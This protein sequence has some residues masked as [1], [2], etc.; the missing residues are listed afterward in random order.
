MND[1]IS[2]IP[3]CYRIYS[4]VFFVFQLLFVFLIF[5][6]IF[7]FWEILR[8]RLLIPHKSFFIESSIAV[9]VIPFIIFPLFF[10]LA[11]AG[12]FRQSLIIIQLSLLF[13]SF[14]KG[15]ALKII[16]KIRNKI[17]LLS[18]GEYVVLAFLSFFAYW[19]WIMPFPERFNGHFC[20]II[21][22]IQSMWKSGYFIAITKEWLNYDNQAYIWPPNAS[23]FLSFFSMPYLKFIDIRP[24]FLVP[25][26][27]LFLAWGII[28]ENTEMLFHDHKIGNLAFLLVVFSYNHLFN[29]VIYYDIFSPLIIALFM[30]FFILVYKR[31]RADSINF[32]ILAVSFTYMARR[33]LFLLF[34]AIISIAYLWNIIKTRNVSY[35]LKINKKLLILF[36]IPAVFWATFTFV[37]YKSPFFPHGGHFVEKIFP[38]SVQKPL[39]PYTFAESIQP[40]KNNSEQASF[41]KQQIIK[42]KSIKNHRIP[43][44]NI[45]FYVENFFPVHLSRGFFTFIK[46]VFCGLSVSL[47][48]SI[49]FL[50]FLFA[51]FFIKGQKDNRE[52]AWLFLIGYTIV[53]YI[54]FLSYIRYAQ[55]LAYI[56]SPFSSYFYFKALRKQ[57]FLKGLMLILFCFGMIFWAYNEWGHMSK[58][59]SLENIR[60]LNPSYKNAVS[61]LAKKSNRSEIGIETE[62]KEILKARAKDS[63]ILYM[64]IEPGLLIPTILNLENFADSLFLE[65]I[66]AEKL[67]EAKSFKELKNGINFYGITHIYKPGRSHVDFENTLLLRMLKQIKEYE[68]LVPVEELSKLD[69]DK[70]NKTIY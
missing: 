57:V 66:S 55:Y 28:K 41:L 38:A 7:H 12:W 13:L 60:F 56:I 39:E 8:T 24:L 29:A 65:S 16:S 68:F 50:G 18:F 21:N 33:Q 51:S 23:F 61:R 48:T 32:I 43:G 27:L 45:S 67:Y 10:L 70:M 20:T 40:K 9:V 25:G 3:I 59:N 14:Y 69:S 44:S 1:A 17:K 37:K 26:F 35:P 31:M 52:V 36:L 11:L 46:N 62:I 47:L 54:F 22:T 53:M 19:S 58:D 5:S 15:F 42:L 6:G 63:K 2:A 49:G 34:M 30:Y 64:D 4:P